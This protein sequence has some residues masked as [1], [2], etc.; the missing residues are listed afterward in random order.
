[1]DLFLLFGNIILYAYT[2]AVPFRPIQAFESVAVLTWGRFDRAPSCY[3]FA[4]N[5]RN[6][7]MHILLYDQ[8]NVSN[9]HVTSLGTLLN[10]Y[11]YDLH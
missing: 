4:L 3:Y 11:K 10:L 7:S 1:M 9:V 5:E 6:E 8:R 2:E